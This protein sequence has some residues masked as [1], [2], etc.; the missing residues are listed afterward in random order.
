MHACL[1]Q[2]EFLSSVASLALDSYD[3]CNTIFESSVRSVLLAGHMPTHCTAMFSWLASVGAAEGAAELHEGASGRQSGH[4]WGC[5]DS[6]HH[7]H[8][9][10]QD[11][12]HIL[13]DDQ[14]Y[15]TLPIQLCARLWVGVSF[16]SVAILQMP[17][18]PL[19]STRSLSPTMAGSE[20]L[21]ALR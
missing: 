15:E 4:G 19:L 12:K 21:C 9:H 10:V 8:C 14:R 16:C 5:A 7:W 1:A 6:A 3:T 20:L 11:F 2:N 17:L 13:S 18:R